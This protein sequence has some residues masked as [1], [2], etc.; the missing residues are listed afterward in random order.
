M[1]EEKLIKPLT[2]SNI[3]SKISLFLFGFEGRPRSALPMIELWNH[4]FDRFHARRSPRWRYFALEDS[5]HKALEQRADQEQR[6][7]EEIQAELVA[8][9]LAH[10]QTTDWLVE[11]WGHL[12]PRE[13]EVT[14][15]TCL[16]YT[17][18]QIANRMHISVE[19]VKTHVSN[20]LV[21]FGLH[22]KADLREAL[23]GWNFSEWGLPQP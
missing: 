18:R 8:A 2:N 7:P 4:L 5:L 21:K 14:A 19:T 6:S 3:C 20:I 10:L 17:N 11:C 15:L 1:K 9:G 13:Q 16:R 12:S 22:G 23:S